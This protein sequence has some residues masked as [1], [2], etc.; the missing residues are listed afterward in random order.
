MKRGY[1]ETPQ[2][3]LSVTPEILKGQNDNYENDFEDNK[4]DIPISPISLQV[5]NFNDKVQMNKINNYPEIDE[6]CG[7][8]DLLEKNAFIHDRKKSVSQ[9][10]HHS[11]R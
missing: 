1:K 10:N 4:S 5:N 6:L 2:T 7:N 11:F 8:V 3:N 9:T